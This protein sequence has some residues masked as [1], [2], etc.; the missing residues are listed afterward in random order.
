[1]YLEMELFQLQKQQGLQH[2]RHCN[3]G[4]TVTSEALQQAGAIAALGSYDRSRYLKG[5]GKTATGLD[6][7]STLVVA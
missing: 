1:M 3:I 2:R 7:G 6:T 5:E 4:G